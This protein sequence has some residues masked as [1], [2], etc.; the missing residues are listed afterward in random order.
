MNIATTLAAV[1]IALG[2]TLGGCV[3]AGRRRADRQRIQRAAERLAETAHIITRAIPPDGDFPIMLLVPRD[4]RITPIEPTTANLDEWLRR[5]SA[6]AASGVLIAPAILFDGEE[7]RG[8]E[9]LLVVCAAGR[10]VSVQAATVLRDGEQ[11]PALTP[12]APYNLARVTP[13][14]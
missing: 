8:T 12:F 10:H 7:N 1:I 14:I 4:G 11:H 6:R 3:R 5:L 13:R 9:I 2:I